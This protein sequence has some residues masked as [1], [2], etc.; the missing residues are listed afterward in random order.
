MH[1]IYYRSNQVRVG[2]I[3]SKISLY[4]QAILSFGIAETKEREREKRRREKRDIS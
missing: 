4:I 3:F 1:N 2:K